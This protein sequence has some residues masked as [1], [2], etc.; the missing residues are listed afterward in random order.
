MIVTADKTTKC[1]YIL[2]GTRLPPETMETLLT[3]AGLF[4]DLRHEIRI[5]RLG[6]NLVDHPFAMSIP[7]HRTTSGG[8]VSGFGT[9]I[10]S[11]A[12]KEP[13]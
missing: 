10:A 12:L 5:E 13:R 4:P 6:S 9:L 1:H 2:I 11:M 3:K 7:A 8:Y